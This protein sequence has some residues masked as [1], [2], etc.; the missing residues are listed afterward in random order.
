MHKRGGIV[1]RVVGN[2]GDIWEQ[3]GYQEAESERVID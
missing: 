3:N 2:E 1:M